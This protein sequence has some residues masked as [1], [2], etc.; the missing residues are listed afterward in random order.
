VNTYQHANAR[1][2]AVLAA[3]WFTL[4]GF[5]AADESSS[6]LNL[7]AAGTAWSLQIP[8]EKTVDFR[9]VVSFDEAGVP[10]ASFLYPAPNAGGFL[11]AVLTHG[12]LIDSA[13][14]G[15]KER[16]QSAADSV[17]VAYRDVLDGLELKSI[18][19][20]AGSMLPGNPPLRV[21]VPTQDD[22]IRETIVESVPVYWM[23][24]D[25]KAIILDNVVT[26][27]R[28]GFDSEKPFQ[29]V[30][31]VVSST[32]SETKPTEHW[33]AN[34][35]QPLKEEVIRLLSQSLQIAFRELAGDKRLGESPFR[36]V[37]YQEG[38]EERIERAQ[39]L[40]DQCGRMLLRSLR[41]SLL[42]VP[43]RKASR[44]GSGEASCSAL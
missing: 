20:Q 40:D 39:V 43:S 16:M 2:S 7:L 30:V 15:Q 25:E 41:G 35:G 44:S 32:R 42:S 38:G 23:T 29:R 36:T 28:P 10:S 9:G 21:V 5:A 33:K 12:F 18:A 37:R 13:K 17:L 22:A 3:F 34:N 26:I 24:Q 19:S 14:K 4:S 6:T 1:I 11:A 27:G 8:T 31:R